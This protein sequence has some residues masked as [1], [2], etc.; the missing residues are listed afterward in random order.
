LAVSGQRV[1]KDDPTERPTVQSMGGRTLFG[2]GGITPDV[3]V[4]PDTLTL[5]EQEAVQRIFRS[6]GLFSTALFS[7]AVSYV[8]Q[9]PDLKLGFSA[10]SA[11]LD[12]F[13]RYV[14][15]EH[16]VDL[17]RAD[18]TAAVRFVTYQLER[19]IALQAWDKED[20]FRQ[21]RSTDTQLNEA[22]DL[23]RRSASPQALF[24]VA[25]EA[26]RSSGAAT[27]GVRTPG[28]SGPS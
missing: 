19:E 8:Q 21:V 5:A 12:R 25:G 3:M 13:Y 11:D 9:H 27:F 10:S 17:S 22:I 18:Y 28:A 7:F 16:G 24:D 6:A 1:L 20:A 26:R 14:V 15:D 2:G 23:I 4:L